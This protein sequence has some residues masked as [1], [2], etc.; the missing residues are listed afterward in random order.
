MSEIT[1]EEAIRRT[2]VAQMIVAE[3][4]AADALRDQLPHGA[5]TVYDNLFEGVDYTPERGWTIPQG[6]DGIEL[7]PTSVTVLPEGFEIAGADTQ[8]GG[9]DGSA[10]PTVKFIEFIDFQDLASQLRA[11]EITREQAAAA[12]GELNGKS[13]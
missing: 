6:D 5:S 9:T 7:Q 1:K 12:L 13:L 8:V 3:C 2:V 10:T 11:G 4:Q